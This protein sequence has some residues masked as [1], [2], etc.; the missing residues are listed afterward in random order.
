M[1]APGEQQTHE[2]RDQGVYMRFLTPLR[3][4]AAHRVIWRIS[5][6]GIVIDL[7]LGAPGL[8]RP[9]YSDQLALMCC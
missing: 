8:Q 9:F 2:I 5:L 6:V 1:L 4:P 3:C 7:L